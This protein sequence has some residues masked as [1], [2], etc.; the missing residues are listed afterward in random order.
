MVLL[1]ALLMLWHARTGHLAKLTTAGI[2]ALAMLAL[3]AAAASYPQKSTE[4]VDQLLTATVADT[5]RAFGKASPNIHVADDAPGGAVVSKQLDALNRETLYRAWLQGMFR[6]PDGATARDFGPRLFRV[7][8]LTWTEADAVKNE[9]DG[10]GKRI[11][12]NKKRQ[13]ETLAA[14]LQNADPRAYDQFT[15]NHGRWG[16]M[17]YAITTSLTIDVLIAVALVFVL[18]ALLAIR[19]VVPLLPALTTLALLDVTAD[20]MRRF[21]GS[22]AGLIIRGPLM[23][24]AAM[25]NMVVVLHVLHAAVPPPLRYTVAAVTALV[26]W[27][28]LKPLAEVRSAAR[29]AGTWSRRGVATAVGATALT[30]RILSASRRSEPPPPAPSSAARGADVNQPLGSR[31]H[32]RATGHRNGQGER[33]RP[34]A[35]PTTSPSRSRVEDPSA[36]PTA[37]SIPAARLGEGVEVR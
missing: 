29:S 9:P 20:H 26:L 36:R 23:F 6:D 14:E 17:M 16:A 19:L 4:A 11:L 22:V 37:M 2:W 21:L 10:D 1:V 35:Q 27:R 15:G 24:L 18:I 31:A 32:R 30:T 13:F 28:L 3:G 25:L 5:S 34:S 12:D 33:F 8:H 7:M